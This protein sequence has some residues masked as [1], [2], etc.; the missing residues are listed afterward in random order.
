ML[1][2]KYKQRLDA[3]EQLYVERLGHVEE[4]TDDERES[5]DVA[6]WDVQVAIEHAHDVL[7]KASSYSTVK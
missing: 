6:L 2:F 3:L 5:F 1:S 4:L 7:R